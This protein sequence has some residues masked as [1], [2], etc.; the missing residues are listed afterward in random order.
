MKFAVRGAAAVLLAL[1]CATPAH[2]ANVTVRVEGANAT[3]LPETVV[4]VDGSGVPGLGCPN[5][6]AEALDKATKGNWERT[7]FAS[8]IMGETLT[9][10]VAEPWYWGEWVDGKY[11]AGLCNDA[12]KEG[13]EVLLIADLSDPVTYGPT[14]LPTYVTGVPAGGIT[15]GQSVT[16]KVE[17][18]VTDGSPG[19][20]TRQPLAG[21]TVTAGQ[22]TATTGADGTATITPTA[23][24]LF[25]V[26]AVKGRQRSATRK[27]AVGAAA[28][29]QAKA[30]AQAQSTLGPCTTSGTDGRCGSRDTEAPLV[31]L[32]GIAD[33]A[34][35]KLGKAP[36]RLSGQVAADPSGIAAVKLRIAR[37]LGA[38]CW[39]YSGKLERF[40]GARC[41]VAHAKWFKIGE[42][43]DWSYLLPAQLPKGGYTIDVKAFDKAGNVVSTFSRGK[44]RVA[45]LVR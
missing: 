39:Y 30:E 9:F 36:R 25:D 15:L 12:V 4:N 32:A 11:G 22:A 21:A 19:N 10:T 45:F 35:L 18:S 38:K 31:T 44:N 34:V 41:G 7:A 6:A 42:D 3:L 14:V 29:A 37:R 33:R 20:G 43:A 24:G 28:V 1:L 2:A 13:S 40:R 23:E 16:V 5:T 26:R 8:T 27:L 17:Q